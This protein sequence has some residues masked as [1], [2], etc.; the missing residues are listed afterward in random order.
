M[1]I[2]EKYILLKN[3]K[4]SLRINFD[5]KTSHAAYQILFSDSKT[6]HAKSLLGEYGMWSQNVKISNRA[7]ILLDGMIRDFTLGECHLKIFV[8]LLSIVVEKGPSGLF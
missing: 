1:A 3:A 7:K 5:V 6:Y 8:H 2:F 4:I